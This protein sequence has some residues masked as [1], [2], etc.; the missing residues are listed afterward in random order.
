MTQTPLMFAKHIFGS[1]LLLSLCALLLEVE[2]AV[3]SS[4]IAVPVK[5]GFTK[6]GPSWPHN[7]SLSR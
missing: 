3:K 5:Y 7:D 2:D 4:S 1:I 6:L